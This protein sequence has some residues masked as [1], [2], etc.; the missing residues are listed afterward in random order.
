MYYTTV[1]VKADLGHESDAIDEAIKQGM[2]KLVSEANVP[3]VLVNVVP[4]AMADCT[5]LVIMA[6]VYESPVRLAE[7]RGAQ[8]DDALIRTKSRFL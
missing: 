2:S 4:V 1:P 7:V 6:K 5:Y 8:I 3:L